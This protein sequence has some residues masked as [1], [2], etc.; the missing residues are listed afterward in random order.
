VIRLAALLVCLSLALP[1][2]AGDLAAV[3]AELNLEKRARRALDNADVALKAAEDAYLK[4]GD[5]ERAN[6]ALDELSQSVELAFTS[7]RQTGKSP[8]KSPRRFKEAEI[9]TREL[10]RLLADFRQGMSALDR[11]EIDKVHA[12]IQKVHDDLLAGIMGGK[13]K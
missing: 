13:K 6:A 1:L 7:L 5:L 12:A 3:K 10:L 11:D 9:K 8:V 4:D 2:G